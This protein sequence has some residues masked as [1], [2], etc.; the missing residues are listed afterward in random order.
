MII[1][2]VAG[3][4]HVPLAAR[5]V[6]PRSGAAERKLGFPKRIFAVTCRGLLA[7]QSAA[8]LLI[9]SAVE[10]YCRNGGKFRVSVDR[11]Q[12]AILAR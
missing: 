11:I 9:A 10:N 2:D 3:L 12:A 8:M 5:G 4:D 6:Q 1:L 7:L